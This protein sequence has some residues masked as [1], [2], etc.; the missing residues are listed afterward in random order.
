LAIPVNSKMKSM[1]RILIIVLLI[2]TMASC[3]SSRRI[4]TA[5]VNTDSVKKVTIVEP[6]KEDTAALIRE[7]FGKLQGQHI[8]FTTFSGEMDVDY[9]DGD[10]KKINVN[11]NL[12]MYKDSVIW[13]R[14][15]GIFNMEGL[16][17]YITKD[18]V[19]ILNKQDKV[20]TERSVAFLQEMTD[21]PLT[22]TSLQDLLI[23]NPVFLD[24][25]ISSFSR[26][27]NTISLYCVSQ[28]FKNL[29]TLAD[30]TRQMQSAKLDDTDDQRNRTCFLGYDDY[31]TDGGITFPAK[32]TI[33]V[34]EKKQLD[35]KL[36]FKK[37]SFNEELNFPFSVPKNYK[38]N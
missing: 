13:I 8:N 4:Q 32:R 9:Q 3:H 1:N 26:G 7:N 28:F 12:R 11:A 16:R 27:N 29:L 2:V 21:L 24:S 37:F 35:I 38:H 25:N 14:V 36:D 17:A 23:G 19:K 5:V 31:K 34:S 30:D 6:P 20:Y 22:L 18:S 33:R 15:S 10:G